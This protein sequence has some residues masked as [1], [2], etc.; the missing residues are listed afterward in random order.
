[1][2]RRTFTTMLAAAPFAGA[3]ILTGCPKGSVNLVAV[4]RSL[5]PLGDGFNS[6]LGLLL[7]AKTIDQKK[8]DELIALEIPKKAK[9]LGDYLIGLSTITQGNQQEI[10]NK[11]GEA[12][13]LFRAFFPRIEPGTTAARVLS[14]LT[15]A[16]DGARI[17]VSILNPPAQSFAIGDSEKGIA[18]KTVTVKPFHVPDDVK[19]YIK[20]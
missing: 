14:V 17:A 18:A 11:L 10:V 12:V 16:I 9:A 2:N 20:R 6:E 8:Y 19:Q 1:M 4:G 13:D 3:T 5:G 7:Q 15:L